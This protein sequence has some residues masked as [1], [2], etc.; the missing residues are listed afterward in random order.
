MTAPI[1]DPKAQ[2]FPESQGLAPGRGR[3]TGRKILVVGGGQRTIPDPDPPIGNGRAASILFARE[4]ARVAVAD[5]VPEAARDTVKAIAAEQGS[6]LALAADVAKPAEIERMVAEA[7]GG[8][9]G[10]DGLFLNVGISGP[11]LGLAGETAEEWDRVMAINLRSHMLTCRSAWPLLADGAAIVFTASI[12]GLVPNSMK[13]SYDTS[14]TALIGLCG[15]VAREGM[16]RGIRANIVAP[17][18]M[19]T[20]L[21]RD[22]TRRRPQRNAGPLPFG[23]QGT[24][25]EVAY[26]A[27]F[28]L[29]R[30][31]AYITGQSLVVDGG[32]IDLWWRA[33]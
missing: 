30:E 26:A 4:G 15:H 24:G 19:D 21:G 17:G 18:L 10:L 29:S 5:L 31:S 7:H 14:K 32:L 6:A 12:S 16:P 8:L 20:A 3:L 25:W 28:L 27:L 1:I 33:G 22:A 13:P 11:P 9:G 23:R 2:M